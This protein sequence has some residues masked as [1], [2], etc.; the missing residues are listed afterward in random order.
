MINVH[1]VITNTN[2]TKNMQVMAFSESKEKSWLLLKN[3]RFENNHAKGVGCGVRAYDVA[4]V[5]IER[6]HFEN[7]TS[8]FHGIVMARNFI[9][10]RIINCNII[11][12][13][14]KF[15]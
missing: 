10:I 4:N 7:N 2:F 1:L 11:R 12:K 5:T 15:L 13:Q 9:H 14:S 3:C 6:C 8:P